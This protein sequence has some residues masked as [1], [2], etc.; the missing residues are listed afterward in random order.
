[1]KLFSFNCCGM[2]SP[3]EKLALK[4]LFAIELVDIIFLQ[5]T[6]GPT[7]SITHLLESWLPGWTFHSLDAMGR[8]EGLTLGTCNHT[9]KTLRVWGGRGCL[10][11]DIYSP[12]LEAKFR[13]INVYGPC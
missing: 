9:I 1:M 8:S 2:A 4:R 7:S 5:E 3:D 6:L 11:A 12:T 13:I 10:G